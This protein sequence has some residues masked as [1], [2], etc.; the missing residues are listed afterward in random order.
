MERR[1]ISALFVIDSIS[2][3]GAERVLCV[4][5]NQFS[6]LGIQVS[7]AL[8][9]ADAGVAAYQTRGEIV[10]S[11]LS[12]GLGAGKANLIKKQIRL[13]KKI[14]REKPDVVIPFMLHNAILTLLSSIGLKTPVLIR[15]ASLPEKEVGSFIMRVLTPCLLRRAA[16]AV[17]QN[18]T[19]KRYYEKY[20]PREG[21]IIRNPVEA[22]PL[23]ADTGRS[24]NKLIIAAGRLHE[25][26]NYPLLLESFSQI[27][28][29]FPEWRLMIYGEGAL[30]GE[31]EA[32]ARRLGFGDSVSFPGFATNI[33]ERMREASIFVI[34]SLYEGLPNSL[35]EAMCMGLPCVTTDFEGGGA[36][37]LITDG[38]NGLIVANNDAAALALAMTRLIKNPEFA[39]RLGDRARELRERLAADRIA[40]KWV[41]YIEN[42]LACS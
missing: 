32:Q 27:R 33:Q 6:M 21:V 3:G 14:K 42:I 25:A 34:C 39:Q 24:G 12:A 36:R 35:I 31:L 37:E 9:N 26:K 4:L 23:W 38:K 10:I 16:G 19:Q 28:D 17:F 40:L 15:P 2:G 1:L 13:C 30:S 8:M 11:D 20:L 41:H 5:A 7:I 22:H 18:N 29:A